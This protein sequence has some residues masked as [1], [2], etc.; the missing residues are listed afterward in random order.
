[1]LLQHNRIFGSESCSVPKCLCGDS[2]PRL[3]SRAKL[4]S[5]ANIANA[6]TCPTFLILQSPPDFTTPKGGALVPPLFQSRKRAFPFPQL[7]PC[8]G[9]VIVPIYERT[10]RVIAPGPDVELEE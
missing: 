3:S 1:M 4:D 8:T 5:L 6:L 2:R 7:L 10:L 9:H